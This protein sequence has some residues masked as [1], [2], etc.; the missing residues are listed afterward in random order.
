MSEAAFEDFN[1]DRAEWDFDEQPVIKIEQ[2]TNK[3]Q[4]SRIITSDATQVAPNAPNLRP[5]S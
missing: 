1:L 5:G 2:K 3:S 4:E